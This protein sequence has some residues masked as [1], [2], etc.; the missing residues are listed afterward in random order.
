[1]FGELWGYRRGV[2]DEGRRWG[3]SFLSGE[4]S[5]KLSQ[6]DGESML[7]LVEEKWVDEHGEPVSSQTLDEGVESRK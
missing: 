6:K 5:V 7:D 1:M 2:R 4:M 3:D